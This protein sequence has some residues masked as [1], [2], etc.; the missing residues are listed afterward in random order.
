MLSAYFRTSEEC[1]SLPDTSG[2]NWLIISSSGVVSR[3]H[4][5]SNGVGTVGLCL[6]GLKLWVI[7]TPKDS[8][9]FYSTTV[10][11]DFQ[12]LGL[13]DKFI[14]QSILMPAGTA[15]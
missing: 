2:M 9:Y 10:Y 4:V 7:G 12:D 5:D 1:H 15:M 8:N 6:T 13:S 11:S 14:W 3:A